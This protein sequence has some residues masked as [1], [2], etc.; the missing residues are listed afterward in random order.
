MGKY[1]RELDCHRVHTPSEVALSAALDNL[2]LYFTR[3]ALR[4]DDVDDLEVLSLGSGKFTRFTLR[5]RVFC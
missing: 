1:S 2:P 3:S 4:G 5:M